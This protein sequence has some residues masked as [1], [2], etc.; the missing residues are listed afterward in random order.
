MHKGQGLILSK[1]G[2]SFTYP[3][4]RKKAE[5]EILKGLAAKADLLVEAFLAGPDGQMGIGYETLKGINPKLKF[6]S[7]TP[8]GHWTKSQSKM[9][10]L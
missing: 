5:A 6:A 8:F 2:T 4:S 10:G 3:E 1:E 7:I 9:A